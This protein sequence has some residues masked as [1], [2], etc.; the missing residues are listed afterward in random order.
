MANH[1]EWIAQGQEGKFAVKQQTKDLLK[2]IEYMVQ[3]KSYDDEFLLLAIQ[4][5]QFH[6]ELELFAYYY[7][8]YALAHGK[9]SLALGYA[10][11]AYGKRK[12]SQKIWALLA[13]IY[14][15]L[16]KEEVSWF[17]QA[18]GCQHY[19]QA[20]QGDVPKEKLK[21]F[22]RLASYAMG[23]PRP[24]PM[25]LTTVYFDSDMKLHE[26]G[27]HLFI[28]QFLPEW[29]G[30]E[31]SLE[32]YRHWC[33]VCNSR[34]VKNAR[35]HLLEKSMQYGLSTDVYAD[36]FFDVM[37]ARECQEFKFAADSECQNCILPI[38]GKT[39][40]QTIQIQIDGVEKETQLGKYEFSF[41]RLEDPVK[42]SADQPFVIGKPVFLQHH[43]KRRKVVLNIL[44]D[45]LS[46]LEVKRQGYRSI[47]CMMKFFQRGIIFDN[48]YSVTEYTYPSLAAIETGCYMQKIQVF[49]PKCMVHLDESY[50]TL[51]EKMSEAGY[52]CANLMGDGAG[53]F[54]GVTRGYDR[55]LLSQYH[56]F[57]FDG[58]E[59]VIRHLEAFSECD[60]FLFLHITDVHPNSNKLQN[61]LQAQTKMNLKDR[62][63]AVNDVVSVFLSK[64]KMN[65]YENRDSMR[66]VDR[67]LGN[68]FDYI[69]S[70]YG[71]EEYLVHLYSDHGASVYSEQPWFLSEE[72]CHAAL[73]MRGG[74]VPSRGLVKELVSGVDIY[75]SVLRN[76]G[77]PLE[78]GIDG[79]LPEVLGG[80]ERKYVFSNSIYPGQTFKL[81]IRDCDYEFRLEAEDFTNI[82]G[83]VNFDKFF[84]A[85]YTRDERH[86][87]VRDE[88]VEKRFLQVAEDYTKNMR[89]GAF[90]F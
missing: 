53:V 90:H 18:L 24:A 77:L 37:K 75:P 73:M 59:R 61:S 38:A 56:G 40:K 30:R 67:L 21:N 52:Y 25:L 86:E 14:N 41:F 12:M 20:L 27:A 81:C 22:C 10:L 35:G 82:D 89:G 5:R 58:V 62:L 2:R 49:N 17:Y 66:S 51:S 57:A 88:Q 11:E 26:G 4:F 69:L 29:P 70:H 48:H 63:E 33:G 83:T 55:L 64:N 28:G 16:G 39:E 79:N 19:G 7:A 13:D 15:Q 31:K 74:G 3:T 50:R 76:A 80:R 47:P 42:I 6:P 8:L 68:L 34:S 71:E 1:S 32:E 23:D 46:W 9:L 72:Q 45:G 65:E 60:N 36:I 44:V 78:K 85:V 84:Y 54:N 43:P 87:L